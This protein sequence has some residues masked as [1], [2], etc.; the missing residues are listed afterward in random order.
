MQ[1][2]PYHLVSVSP[3]PLLSSVALLNLALSLAGYI[4]RCDVSRE[5]LLL[6]LLVVVASVLVWTRDVVVEGVFLG[7]HTSDVQRRLGLRILLFV[8]SEVMVFVSIFWAYFHSALAPSVELGVAWPPAG[9][10]RIDPLALPLLNTVL[11]LSSG[12]AVTW[13]HHSMVGGSRSGALYGLVLTI[14]LALVFTA[15]QGLEYV[16]APFDITDRVFGSTFYL[17]TGT[18]GFHVILGTIFILVGCSRLWSYQLTATHHVG[19]QFAIVYWHFVDVVWLFLYVAVY[20][21]GA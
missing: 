18:H 4:H 5:A 15:C 14:A 9:I 6:S 12:A 8:V 19:L 2:H 7:D 17:S 16:A 1:S 13:G 11:L 3:W 21:F 10:E 20:G